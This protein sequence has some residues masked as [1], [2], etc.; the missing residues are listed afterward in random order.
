M[1]LTDVL[2]VVPCLNEAA[3]LPA[4][5]D[6]LIAD[7]PG[8]TIVVADG[9]S[10]DDSRAIVERLAAIHANLHLLD[11]P[12]RIQGAGVNLAVRRFGERHRWL[13]RVDAHCHYPRHY[14][15]GL[16][17][18]AQRQDAT[19]VVVPMR[20]IGVQCFQRA[21][22]AAQN[23][24]LGTGGSAHRH[25]GRGSFVEHGHH[26]AM[27]IDLFVAAGG[28]CERQA[29]NEDAELDHRLHQAG[30]R[31]WLE[32]DGAIDYLPRRDPVA[33]FRQ[34]QRYG[35]GRATTIARHGLRPRLRQRV[36]LVVAPAIVLLLAA[37]LLGWWFALPAL[38]WALLCLGYG[39]LLGARARD[40]CVALAGVA[41]MTMHLA[42]SCG[43][44]RWWL[45]G[46]RLDQVPR[47]LIP[48]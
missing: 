37:P 36:P 22:A 25:V 10:T 34:Y 42:W 17:T 1:T 6:H 48:G 26:A 27:R 20:T 32:P 16:L 11:N 23:S 41:A 29:V 24:A 2:V 28:Y 33:L 35:A 21:V 12:A 4:L 44:W 40:R 46:K 31:I 7:T 38:A 47:P 9:G 18:A 5:L 45:T 15:A 14:V 8:A 30:G 13:V 3:H 39:V 19:S 43:Y